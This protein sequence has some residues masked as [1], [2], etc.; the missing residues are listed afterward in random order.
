MQLKKQ[1]IPNSLFLHVRS[2]EIAQM[3]QILL[4]GKNGERDLK[5]RSPTESYQ[6]FA[7]CSWKKMKQESRNCRDGDMV[8]IWENRKSC[9]RETSVRP[10]TTGYHQRLA[11]IMTDIPGNLGTQHNPVL[12]TME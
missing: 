8:S 3:S 6:W 1:L 2:F 5:S 10:A 7:F 11:H 12:W 4:G 9:K